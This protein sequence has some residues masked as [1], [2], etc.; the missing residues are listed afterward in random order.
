MKT[1]N[2][3][4]SLGKKIVVGIC[5][6]VIAGGLIAGGH[7]IAPKTVTVEKQVVT[8]KLIS[9]PTLVA[10]V[11]N[12]SIELDSVKYKVFQEDA[13]KSFMLLDIAKEIDKR[14]MRELYNFMVDKD[15]SISDKEDITSITVMESTYSVSDLSNKD[16]S[17]VQKLKVK[18]EDSDGDSKKEY[19]YA[20]AT[21]KDGEL[22]ELDFALNGED[23]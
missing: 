11:A 18:Y 2:S 3:K 5:A 13:F 16:G 23:L 22:D 8:E 19:V 6:V 15:L 1:E 4:M 10:S 17:I 12:L 9:D 7:Y 20:K 14:D 21:F